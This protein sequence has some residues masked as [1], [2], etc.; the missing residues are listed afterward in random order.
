MKK[1]KKS[2]RAAVPLLTHVSTLKTLMLAGQYTTSNDIHLDRDDISYFG[3]ACGPFC[4]R[5]REATSQHADK[6]R[7]VSHWLLLWVYECILYMHF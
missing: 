4:C 2:V 3:S 1:K 7:P 6:H 5:L